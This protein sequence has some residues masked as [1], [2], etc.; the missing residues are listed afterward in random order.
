[1][2]KRIPREK[3]MPRIPDIT[4]ALFWDILARTP[5]FAQPCYVTLVATGMRL[6]EYLRCDKAHL[7]RLT[8]SI[9]VPGTKAAERKARNVEALGG[10]NSRPSRR[11]PKVP[12]S[13]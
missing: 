11:F 8:C 9:D 6:G 1:V 10:V 13:E 7:S 4:I 12:R 5:D 2:V 3:E